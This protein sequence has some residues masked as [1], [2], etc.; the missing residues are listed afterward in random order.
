MP[1]YSQTNTQQIDQA[2]YGDSGKK[3]SL[4]GKKIQ[5]VNTKTNKSVTVTIE[6][7]C[8][9][10]RDKNSVDL[11]SAAFKQIGTVEEGE[12][13]STFISLRTFLC[14]FTNNYITF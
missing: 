14:I 3:S 10:C 5:V 7:D 4:C 6:D 13:D 2:R 11:S 1:Y 9:T 8:P 12:V